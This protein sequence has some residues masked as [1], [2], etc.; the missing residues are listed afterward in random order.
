MSSRFFFTSSTWGAL[1]FGVGSG[2]LIAAV[3]GPNKVHPILTILGVGFLI[4]LLLTG[5]AVVGVAMMTVQM[6]VP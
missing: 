5:A 2:T 4:V 3:G 1:M 6:P